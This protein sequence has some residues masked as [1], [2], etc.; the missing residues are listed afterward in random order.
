MDESSITKLA[1]NEVQDFIRQHELE[2]EVKL[3]L[4]HKTLFDLP[5]SLIAQQ[6][7][8]RKKS[9]EK[10]PIWHNTNGIVFPPSLNL[11]QCSSEAT[12]QYKARW[13]AMLPIR[14]LFIDV[15]GGFGIDSYFLSHVFQ[16]GVML[17]PNNEL[18]LIAKHNHQLLLADNL[19]YLPINAAQFLQTEVL[20]INLLYIDPSRRS[21]TKKVLK[22]ADCTP[23]VVELQEQF[24]ALS[25]YVLVKASPLL[26]IQQG[27]RELSHVEEVVV[28]AVDNEVKELLFLQNRKFIGEPEIRAVDFNSKLQIQT[29]FVFKF[30]DERGLLA[31]TSAP[32]EFLYEP[33]AYI[34]KAGAFKSAG[35]HYGLKK[36]HPNTHLYTSE[37]PVGEFAGRIFKIEVVHPQSADI[38]QW[39][40]DGKANVT[41]R[42][43]PLTPE[44]LKKKLK[45]KDGGDKYVI[46]FSEEKRKTIVIATR[47]K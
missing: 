43:Y 45:L 28:L 23:N 16:R 41:T 33:S 5:F 35:L 1:R 22:L 42:N 39:L 17:E 46:A 27:L 38:A 30:S 26:D 18:L 37:K 47:I 11:E 13:V 25:Q 20:P 24:L 19:E 8:G 40:P 36:I 4:K 15:T 14:D 31:E 7:I 6:L 21:G 12:A 32:Q 44:E 9:K 34:L 2:D 10:L 29:D 3:S